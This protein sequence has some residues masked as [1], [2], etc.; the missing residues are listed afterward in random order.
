MTELPR[1]LTGRSV[2]RP[3]AV[4]FSFMEDMDKTSNK[5]KEENFYDFQVRHLRDRLKRQITE[6]L[7]DDGILL[8]PS[9]PKTAPFHHETV[10]TC[11]N[12]GYTGLFNALAFP[13]LQCPMGLDKK[14]LPLGV[15]VSTVERQGELE[16][17]ERNL[18]FKN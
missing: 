17:G 18:I 14:G 12:M 7:G 16:T 8:F 9:W 5:K 4:L 2:H 10:F 15:Q 13:V 3:G 6:L 1:L 11:T